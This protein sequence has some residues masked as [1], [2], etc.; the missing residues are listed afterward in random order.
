MM[1]FFWDR[2]APKNN[3]EIFLKKGANKYWFGRT[4][5]ING[6]NKY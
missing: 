6:A 5:F 3:K 1:N 4:Y 2:K